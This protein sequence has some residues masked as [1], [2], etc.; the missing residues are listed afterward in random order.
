MKDLKWS[1]LGFAY[2]KTDYNVRCEFRDGKW[3]EV[4]ATEDTNIDIHMAATALH[5]GQEVFEGLKAFRGADGKARLFRVEENAKRMIR[6]AEYLKMAAP[7]VELFTEMCVKCVQA[8]KD[9]IPPY[10]TGAS[11]YLRP[12]LIGTGAQVGVKPATEYMLIVFVTPVGPYFK[13]G[14]NPIKVMIDR[15]HD[16]AAPKG[17]GHVKVG[18]NYASSLWAGEAAQKAGFSNVL[19]LDPA[20]KTYIEECGAANFFGI[21]DGKYITPQSPSILPSITNM[22]LRQI[23]EDLGLKVENRNIEVAE[24]AKFEEAGACGTAAVISPIGTIYDKETG[25]T[26]TFGDGHTAGPWSTKLYKT[27]QGIQYGE[28]KDTHGW[29]TVVEV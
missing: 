16:R 14:F 9:Y 18:G 8:N 29:N 6:S 4:Y 21:R 26:Y 27:L 25:T 12:F 1:E 19:Y 22:S 11:L 5:Y 24:L 10:G 15:D 2:T 28:L 3:G 7:P 23:A 17:T 13:E 20:T